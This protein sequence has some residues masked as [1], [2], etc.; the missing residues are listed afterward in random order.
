MPGGAVI[1]GEWKNWNWGV[2]ADEPD[3][4][5]F[6]RAYI[7]SIWALELLLLLRRQRDRVWTP[8]GIVKELRASTNL[9]DDNLAR[10]ERHGLVLQGDEGWRFQPANPRL[11]LLVEKLSSLYRERPMHVMSMITRS[12]ALWSLADAFRIKKDE[13]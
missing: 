3:V 11:D 1:T 5:E 10:F 4:A 8:A 13:T 7:P 6:I 2:V 9:V 12:N